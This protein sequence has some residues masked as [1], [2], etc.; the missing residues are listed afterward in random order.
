MK[1]QFTEPDTVEWLGATYKFVLTGE[2][3]D[4]A[5]S[6][7]D[8]TCPVG[9]GPPRHVHQDAE[10]TFVMLSGQCDFW[11]EGKIF[12]AIEGESILVPRG[13]EHSFRVTG[14]EPSRHLV[15]L[16]PAGFEGFFREMAEGDYAIPS[17][18]ARIAEIARRYQLEFTG[19]PL[20][21]ETE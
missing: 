15:I 3:T 14:S 19:P 4:G 7:V 20:G 8:S 2:H 11:L 16:S 1:D 10:E 21:A 6:I 12:S 17:D 13:A 9:S 18:M 5:L